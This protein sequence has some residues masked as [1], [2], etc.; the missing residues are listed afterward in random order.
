M[1]RSQGCVERQQLSSML[2]HCARFSLT[3]KCVIS[4]T[5]KEAKVIDL[6]QKATTILHF[7]L[8]SIIQ[9][10]RCPCVHLALPSNPCHL[11]TLK[12]SHTKNKTL[13]STSYI[14]HR[15]GK[16]SLYCCPAWV[17]TNS[18]N[19]QNNLYGQFSLV[20]WS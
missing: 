19:D 4:D 9:L 2:Y 6:I 14:V 16:T 5:D 3:R 13:L 18:I 7:V 8:F 12:T 17:T 10:L 15:N 11:Q 20:T 1:E